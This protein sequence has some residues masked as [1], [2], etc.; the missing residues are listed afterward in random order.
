LPKKHELLCATRFV[1]FSKRDVT[2]KKQSK[3]DPTENK[4]GKDA[5]QNNEDA[6]KLDS[7]VTNGTDAIA[8][9]KAETVVTAKPIGVEDLICAQ[10]VI[11]P[12]DP[13]Y[14]VLVAKRQIALD[15]LAA[16]R[17]YP[18][19]PAVFYWLHY[20]PE[21]LNGRK[22]QTAHNRLLGVGDAV[23]APPPPAKP[24]SKAPK[25]RG[26]SKSKGKDK[27]KSSARISADT[28]KSDIHQAKNEHPSQ[29]ES[30]P[31]SLAI[32]STVPSVNT[33]AS[34]AGVVTFSASERGKRKRRSRDQAKTKRRRVKPD[35]E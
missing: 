32:N 12:L 26:G 15:T 1:Y 6:T 35:S 14:A 11:S 24:R 7:G 8:T 19:P 22:G 4:K 25:V 13:D 31:A 17:I 33:N 30:Q 34:D 28:D 27:G 29:Q 23:P 9:V 20:R 3:R 21:L 10:V 2:D 5:T 18:M 16:A